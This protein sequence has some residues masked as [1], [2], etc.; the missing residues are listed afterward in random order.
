M[1][2]PGSQDLIFI[3]EE[4][5]ATADLAAALGLIALPGD[6]V[7][8][9]GDLGAGKTVFA[10]G[11][12]AALGV[13]P[14]IVDSPTFVILNEYEGRVPVFHFDAYRLKGEREELTE[15]GFFDE[16]LEDGV[17]LMEW[18]GRVGEYLPALA[19]RVRIEW[20]EGTRRRIVVEEPSDRVR[21][22]LED[23]TSLY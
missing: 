12:C 2:H 10:K 23:R 17:A 9:F 11:F 1:R 13:D 5:E 22:A 14:G 6:F 8:L 21:T 4:P 15:L 16:Q 19:L 7:A 3:T 20:M 18:A